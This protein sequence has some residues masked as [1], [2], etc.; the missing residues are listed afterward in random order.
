[1]TFD[2]FARHR[3]GIVKIIPRRE[4]A[5]DVW[6]LNSPSVLLITGKNRNRKKHL[7]ILFRSTH[8][9]WACFNMLLAV[10]ARRSFFG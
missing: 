6:N 7:E 3:H 9:S 1:M 10:L 2:G 8:Q 4:A 5:R